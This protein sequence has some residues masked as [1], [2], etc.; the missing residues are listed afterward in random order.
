MRGVGLFGGSFD[1]PHEAHYEIAELATRT[2]PLDLLY[3]VPAHHAPLKSSRPVASADDRLAMVSRLAQRHDSWEVL[4]YEIDQARPVSTMETLGH[5]RDKHPDSQLYVLM[6]ADQ[7]AQLH[8]WEDWRG[9]AQSARIVCFARHGAP[10]PI[11]AVGGVIQVI[12]FEA[13]L[14]SSAIRE[15]IRANRSVNGMLPSRVR[16]Y[17]EQRGL[18]K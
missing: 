17:I 2:L 14:S 11:S 4:S 9:L 5:L 13:D 7:A 8:R 1:P 6:G 18:Y 16:G 3:F 12:P 10:A 15:S